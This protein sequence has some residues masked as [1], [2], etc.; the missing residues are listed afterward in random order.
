MDCEKTTML[1]I[2]GDE[3][4]IS[5]IAGRFPESDNVKHLRKNLMNKMDLGSDDDR[6]WKHDHP[7]IPK[8]TG[9]VNNIQKFDAEY[10]NIPFT[11][12]PMIDAI[13]RMLLE[14][15]YEAIVDAGINP[16]D[17]RGTKTGVFI[18]ACFS[19]SDANWFYEKLQISGPVVLGCSKSMFAN[20]ISQW[21]D[22]TGP[23]AI[24]DSACSSS[25]FA[26]EVAYRSMQRGECDAAIVGGANLCLNPVI[27]LQFARLGVLSYDGVCKP[28]DENANG[29]M[30]SETISM[31]Y[32]QKAKRAKRIYATIV[33][34]KTNCDGYKEQ[35]ITFPSSEMQRVLLQEF[36]DECGISPSCL[37]YLE[38]HGTATRVG[39][40]EEI[41]A[42]EK[43]FCKNRQTP[44]LIGSVKSNLGHSEAAAGL[45]QIAKVIIAMET[46]IIPPNANFTQERK[47]VKALEEGTIRVV[48]TATPWKSGFMGVSSFGFGG[49][50][51][52][53]L[54]KSNLKQKVN[55]GTPN[56]DLPRLI[57][58]SG[59]TEHAV[60]SL[61]TDEIEN[62]PIDVEYI[63]LLHDIY[64]DD[65]QYHPYRGYAIIEPEASIKMIK[66]IQHYSGK[67]KP[68]SFVF[69]GI[70]SQW[71]GMGQAL[72]RFPTFY[73]TIE[74]CDTI[75]RTHGIR[76]VD[77]LTNK[78]EAIFNNI[79]NSLVG[80]TVMQIGLIELLK[81]VNIVPDYVVGHSIGELCC[82]YVTGNFTMEQVLLSSY[83]IGLALSETKTI[84]G[85]M[86]DIGLSYEKVKNICP[87]DIDVIY[88]KSQN[89]CS[90]SGPKNSVM[91]FITKL[92][93]NNI[94][95]KEINC[96]NIPLHS[97]YLVDAKATI[98]AYLNRIIPHPTTH[99]QM[100]QSSFCGTHGLSYAEYFTNN[101]LG[102]ILFEE[103]TRLVLQNTMTF[104][105]AKD[106]ILQN[107]MKEHF[108]TTSIALLQIN[109]EDNVKV[110]LQGLGKMYNNGLQPQ[111]ANLYPT[112]QF[113][114]SRGTPMIS[115]SIKWNHSED[116]Y[117]VCF[118]AQKEITSG[119][120]IVN[121]T[122]KDENFEFIS[123]H[124]IDGRNLLPATGYLL[125]IWDTIS[126]L[127]DQ[128]FREA[129]IVFENVKFIRATHIPKQGDLELTIMIQKDSGNFEIIEGGNA[130]VTGKARILFDVDKEKASSHILQGSF[131]EN[132]EEVMKTKDIY[133]EL[134]L[135]GYQY[136]N[137]FRGLKSSSTTAKRGHIAWTNNWVTFMDNM[138]QIKILSIDMRSLYVPTEV[139][140]LVINPKLHT[141]YVRDIKAEE[142]Q[143]PVR[144]Y[145]DLDM[146]ISGGIEIHGVKA[147][148]IFR[149]KPIGN[150]ILEEYKFVAH[151]DG[152]E[153][154]LQES[155]ILSTHLALEYH[156]MIKVNIIE[157][158][159]DNDKI[160][161][162]ELAS[163]LFLEVLDNLPL[164]KPNLSLITRTDRFDSITL[165]P[166]ITTSRSMKLSKD[167]NAML[168]AGFNLLT[169]DKSKTLNEIL[170]ALKN[171]GFLLTRGQPLTRNDLTNAERH[172]LAI[173]LEKRTK[174]EHIV[175][176][177]KRESSRKKTEIIFVNNYE[178][179][180]LEQ[181]KSILN[182]ENN[183]AKII[184]VGEKD[185]ECGLIGLVNCLR[186][187]PG[188][189]LIRGVLIQD[190]TAPKFSL[191]EPLY[192][193]Q[194]QIDLIINV[195]RPGIIWGSYRH[196][197][198]AP[199]APKLSHHAY[200]NQMIRGDLHSLSW[201][202]GPIASNY[203]HEDLV[204]I[205][206]ASINFKDVMIATARIILDD[207][208]FRGR[209]EECFIGLEYV[210]IDNAGRRVMG[211]WENKCIAN[212]HV[213][214][215]SLCWYVP[216]KWTLEDAATVPCAYSTCYCALY[217]KTKIKRNE[218]ILI[219]SGT[220]A[221]GQAAIYLALYEGC[222]IFTTV[223]TPE[224]RRFIR[225]TFPS[226]PEDHIGN[227]RDTSF[228]QMIFRQTNG[229]GVDIVLNSLAED[230]LQASIRCLAKGGRFLE[231]GKFDFIANN[232]LDLSVFSK[233]I[234]FY[235]VMLDNLLSMVKQDVELKMRLQKKLAEGLI[236]GAVQPI[237]RKVFQRDEVEAAFRYMTAGKHIGKIVI[238]I[239]KEN[240]SINTPILALPRY[241]CL[242]SKTYI[243]FGGLGG[244]GL[245]LADWLIIRGAGN[246]V[247]VS[248]KGVRNGYQQMKIDLWK[249][250]GVK[251]LIVSNL[252]ASNVN[253]CESILKTAE[254]LAP[255][256]AIFNLAVVLNDKICQNHTVETF[257]EPFKPK[258]W[259]TQNLDQLS[260]KICLQLR[261][262]VVFSSV[263]CG[264]GNAGQS[265][266]GMANSVMER[267]CERRVQEGLHGLAV[268]W[269]AIGDV[270]LVADMQ[271]DD[272][273]MVIGGTLQQKIGSCI[274]KLEEFLLQEQ[275]VVGSMVV[276]EKR[277]HAF[278]INNIAETVA[279]IMGLKDLNSVARHTPLPELGMDS[280][281][282]VEIK[283]TLEREFD[284]FLTAQ[285][286]R[287]L[288]FAKLIDM[289][290]KDVSM[291]KNDRDENDLTGF[292]L[293]VRLIGNDCLIPDICLD[294][295]TKKNKARKE[296][297]LLPGMEGCSSIFDSL[298]Q[299]IEAPATCLQHGIYNIGTG[300]NS[301]NKI[302]DCLLQHILN[303]KKLNQDFIIV[304]YSMGSLIAIELVRKLEEMNLRGRLVLIDGAP[305][306][307]KAMANQYLSFTTIVEL[308]NNVLLGIMDI[309]QPALSGKLLLELN[310]CTNWDEKL[311]TFIDHVPPT[312]KH[313]SNNNK[314]VCTT[315]YE[316]LIAVH[317]Y[318]VT[319]LP[320]I[321]SP[322]ILIKPIIQALPFSQED[323]GLH[324]ITKGKVKIYYVEGNH[325]TI[326]DNNKVA[327]VINGEHIESVKKVKLDLTD[328]DKITSVKDIYSRS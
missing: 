23:S 138:L 31:I 236:I 105:I 130:I 12:V 37:D 268:Q 172:N 267:I 278:G 200:V 122:L 13:S 276:A 62:Q 18:G 54:L 152:A 241:Y 312:Y 302:A 19:D 174:I 256:D 327:A 260:R 266:Y 44:L 101:L 234:T 259:T 284:V 121:I 214:D 107:V 233:G 285:D 120:K 29:Y 303:K 310:K 64:A 11:E 229:R 264:R 186:R 46:G 7:E 292:K 305:E 34:T 150:P 35:G 194:L 223:G 187:E 307:I 283:Q 231:I 220:G 326:L 308:E 51:C 269:G 50:N 126:M 204:R 147:T 8:R 96:N 87:P 226:I 254:E 6:R 141:Q 323:Y 169:N 77:I 98:L 243:I 199:L 165:P 21:L 91:A 181:L 205:T 304:G 177:K 115:P 192:A 273:E 81:S 238:Q 41:N 248:R 253:D 9:K 277:S 242:A 168:V 325:V 289:F 210:G 191:D 193:K 202:E 154:S 93:D 315:I 78:H 104:E 75:L 97:R 263:S 206:Y 4:V 281:M 274:E 10:F 185:S 84:H 20:R 324:K 47:G 288:N 117:V 38:A 167:D 219:H 251:V 247:L 85:A 316:R 86:A 195:L 149:R 32:L 317:K 111:L 16:K 203:Q 311:N 319:Q 271:E 282:A 286:I 151:R 145:K 55:G 94:F 72:L 2:D 197:P 74:K 225:E 178:F 63:R 171:G 88:V 230:K 110:F 245:E 287:Y 211:V 300:Y 142:K 123:G 144:V 90:I 106:E 49:A 290:D 24:V 262:F 119:E 298:V 237:S 321:E 189:E 36:Y 161:T 113:P 15:A 201:L 146:I 109:H 293:L 28:F 217:F 139:Q 162:E 179:S 244:F 296:I 134:K 140:K 228:E 112:V 190:E 127:K 33:H 45:C 301:I 252:D 209:L 89:I 297:F 25:L 59:R 196:L 291:E 137:L 295:P 279:N 73:K 255:V 272:K 66:E 14:H 207:F 83:Y 175:L 318:D 148:S 188:G 183:V 95:I 92:Q 218:K 60:E 58:V 70:G 80:I 40:P 48:K 3:I 129:P 17:L 158:I 294:L 221:V 250:Y 132:E 166:K 159:E 52:H 68:I 232:K 43:V 79:L 125:F 124:V 208:V 258:A 42:I 71:P 57:V 212:M 306:Q 136:T 309:I 1:D 235:S 143:L 22:I 213:I 176:L 27:A 30:R 56:D 182:I 157:L 222:E 216:D 103:T 131:E 69:S 100:W 320:K 108:D 67:R 99:S 82:G 170:S 249:S 265:N 299:Q 114:V 314:S 76:I 160:T 135:R 328:H 227:S 224:K 246:L 322:I 198:L 61:L 184:L 239:Q 313:M 26:V 257:Q 116:W 102:P 128:M 65:M 275:P 240:E 5:G 133:K 39:D 180:W 156:Q 164:I 153:I 155:I 173:V 53:I 280:M 163:P 215:K 270:G 118:K 261:H